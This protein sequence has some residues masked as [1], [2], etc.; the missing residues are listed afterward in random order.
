MATLSRPRCSNAWVPRCAAPRSGRSSLP[1][2]ASRILSQVE[3]LRAN[4]GHV[5]TASVAAQVDDRCARR[6]RPPEPAAFLGGPRAGDR[7]GR[8]RRL[9]CRR[10][11]HRGRRRR[12]IGR[13]DRRCRVERHRRHRGAPAPT[14]RS[15]M[16]APDMRSTSTLPACRRRP[17]GRTTRAGCTTRRAATGSASARSTCAAAT[18]ASCC[19]R[20]C[21]S[22]ALPRAGGHLR[23][24]GFPRRPRR[25]P[26]GWPATA[27]LS[28]ALVYLTLLR[29]TYH[30][31]PSINF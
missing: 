12:S 8:P 28:R 30:E 18:A 2:L 13:A 22:A 11:A 3:A 24:R 25:D 29:D 1:T 7:R 19:G 16:P 23:G 14:A 20:A 27:T 4:D 9:R 5:V 21:R 10:P 26:P 31:S 6:R 15:S 17:M